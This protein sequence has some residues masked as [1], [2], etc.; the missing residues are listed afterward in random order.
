[1]TAGTRDA[2]RVPL[3]QEYNYSGW[4]GGQRL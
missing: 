3:E 1:M 4:V 2:R